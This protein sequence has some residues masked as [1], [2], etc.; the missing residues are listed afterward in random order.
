M[1]LRTC[2]CVSVQ[3]SDIQTELFF[4]K[5]GRKE[6]LRQNIL[7]VI[8][9][10]LFFLEANMCFDLV[11]LFLAHTALTRVLAEPQTGE[12][13]YFPSVVVFFVFCSSSARLRAFKL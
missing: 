1:C 2:V 11:T 13:C 6:E 7:I 10:Y 4:V 8:F 5:G 9:L 3:R 12:L